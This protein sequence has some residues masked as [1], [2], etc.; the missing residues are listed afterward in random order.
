MCGTHHPVGTPVCATC[1]ASGVPQL[2]LMFECPSCAG[3]GL[4]P[5]CLECPAGDGLIIAEEV[6]DEESS[7]QA[8]LPHD[9]EFV[10][11]FDEDEGGEYEDEPDDEDSEDHDLDDDEADDSELD[12]E[13]TDDD[14]EA[15]SDLED[16]EDEPEPDDAAVVMFDDE[17]EDDR[18]DFEDDDVEEYDD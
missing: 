1:L 15:D 7:A 12:D 2:R 16:F 8:P 13:E 5:W 11:E 4:N 3:L 17:E 10:I 6:G 9:E 18:G 14:P